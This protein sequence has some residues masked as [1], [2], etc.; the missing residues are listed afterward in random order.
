MA[1]I[2][3]FFVCISPHGCFLFQFLSRTAANQ[4]ICPHTYA[5]EVIIGTDVNHT[6]ALQSKF[7]LVTVGET[8]RLVYNHGYLACQRLA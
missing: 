3:I 8:G 5:T 7:T 6:W 4:K 2:V 1:P